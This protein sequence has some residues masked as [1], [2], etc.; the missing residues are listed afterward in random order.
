M[1]SI[2]FADD[3]SS[4]DDHPSVAPPAPAVATKAA[5]TMKPAPAPVPAAAPRPAPQPVP[6]P[7][8]TPAPAPAVPMLSRHGTA[9]PQ[10]LQQAPPPSSMSTSPLAPITRPSNQQQQALPNRPYAPAPSNG[11]QYRP[12]SGSLPPSTASQYVASRPPP[13]AGAPAPPVR[14]PPSS[15]SYPPG[16]SSSVGA[17]ASS[18]GS[19]SGSKQN[20]A[21]DFDMIEPTPISQFRGPPS[22]PIASSATASQP[23]A[24]PPSSQ[25]VPPI[26][27]PPSKSSTI[28][29]STGSSSQRPSGGSSGHV[30]TD[31]DRR[32]EQ[33]LMFTR[34]LMKYLEQKDPAM[35]QHARA[36]IKSCAEKHKQKQQGYESLTSSMHVNLKK[37]VGETYWKKA[38]ALLIHFLRNRKAQ[39]EKD[40]APPQTTVA[41]ASA[42]GSGGADVRR[43]QEE[44]TALQRLKDKSKAAIL[45]AQQKRDLIQRG[46]GK[47]VV[48]PGTIGPSSA[49]PNAPIPPIP[50]GVGGSK[51]AGA[52]SRGH[53]VGAPPMPSSAPA[54]PSNAAAMN[55]S[56]THSRA[57]YVTANPLPTPSSVSALLPVVAPAPVAKATAKTAAPPTTAARAT[58]ATVSVMSSSTTTKSTPSS[59]TTS[60]ITTTKVTKK[61]TTTKKKVTVKKKEKDDKDKAIKHDDNKSEKKSS[62]TS[63]TSDKKRTSSV[64]KKGPDD[65]P[66][67]VIKEMKTITQSSAK[68]S[69][70][71]EKKKTSDA[72]SEKPVKKVDVTIPPKHYE[73]WMSEVDHAISYNWKNAASLLSKDYMSEIS[74]SEEQHVLLYG[75]APKDEKK[76]ATSPRALK[77]Q[78]P[79]DKAR[80]GSKLYDDKDETWSDRNVINGRMAW[81]V[82]HLHDLEGKAQLKQTKDLKGV[83][84]AFLSPKAN[85]LLD[86]SDVTPQHAWVNDEKAEQDPVLEMISEATQQYLKNIM[87]V[88]VRV[89]KKRY[90]VDGMRLWHLQHAH[91]KKVALSASKITVRPPPLMLRL[92]CDVTRQIA[93]AYGNA[94]KTSQR[95]EEAVARKSATSSPLTRISAKRKFAV[96]DE[97]G[98]LL[99]PDAIE[100]EA[101]QKEDDELQQAFLTSTSMGNF[102]KQIYR[103]E[104]KELAKEAEHHA[105]TFFE[106]YG[107]K[108]ASEPP[109]GRVPKKKKCKITIKDLMCLNQDKKAGHVNGSKPW[110]S[111]NTRSKLT[112]SAH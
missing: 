39:Q 4:D 37:A 110:M 50:A 15:N 52:T 17:S 82:V 65:K 19:G 12:S 45:A 22:M 1:E 3:D 93:M 88:G 112:F 77:R 56:A 42:G 58:P 102:S 8:P 98:V 104:A 9:P 29:S 105:G 92:G 89:A 61:K 84:H 70:T 23:S 106:M 78:S 66:T 51:G 40:K 44:Q 67:L 21:F 60:K 90:N 28:S 103:S 35:H 86:K 100:R 32:K 107:G 85:Q 13:G 20:N 25:R 83:N 111:K 76:S 48:A 62:S 55:P 49:L 72:S 46:G 7:V 26:S 2:L 11:P 95:M 73:E 18:T 69:V 59:T 108:F 6:V 81:A 10:G 91:A 47:Q 36:I 33:F 99:D 94:A 30:K 41:S 43:K 80:S 14:M 75:E 53:S 109:F 97:D 68:S 101:K 5:S 57:P 79:L 64:S 63:K 16:A 87:E 24:A 31:A 38:E 54:V 74:I 71:L 96:V 34:V 27:H